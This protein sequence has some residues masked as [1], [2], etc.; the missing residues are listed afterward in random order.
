MRKDTNGPAIP[1]A[2]TTPSPEAEFS[3]GMVGAEFQSRAVRTAKAAHPADRNQFPLE[4]CIECQHKLS[5]T[6]R[7][8]RHFEGL[9]S[10]ALVLPR[11][12][13]DETTA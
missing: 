6:R 11:R 10:L 7:R 2:G 5:H 9:R 12:Q 1:G 3:I 4:T 8:N 13:V